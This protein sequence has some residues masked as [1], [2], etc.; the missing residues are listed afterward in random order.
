MEKHYILLA[1]ESEGG[2]V[3]RAAKRLGM[4]RSSLY[5]KI[6]EY[7]L[8]ATSNAEPTEESTPKD[9]IQVVRKRVV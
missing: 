8:S 5:E 4:A 1:L 9:L 6:R 7:G 2:H 3:A